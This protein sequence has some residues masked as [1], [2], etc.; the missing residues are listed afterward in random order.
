MINP[1]RRGLYLSVVILIMLDT[2]RRMFCDTRPI[3]VAMLVIELL[4]LFVIAIEGIVSVVRW[5]AKRITTFRLRKFLTDGRDLYDNAPFV[6]ASQHDALMWEQKVKNWEKDVR[7]F[8]VENAEFAVFVF[9]HAPLGIPTHV[10][11]SN[12]I[13]H[14]HARFDGVLQT[15]LS[16]M[17]KPDV[18][19]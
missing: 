1:R 11:V 19:F 3:D 14:I 2:L 12:Y 6:Q 18:Y 9:D 15:L 10:F 7:A 17:E 16:I 5:R 13:Q 4:V 8:L